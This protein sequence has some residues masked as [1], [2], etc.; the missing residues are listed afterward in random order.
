MKEQCLNCKHFDEKMSFMPLGKCAAFPDG[1][2]KDVLP[3]DFDHKKRHPEQIN[4]I[5]F[6]PDS[7]ISRLKPKMKKR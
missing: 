4:L 2:P 7:F 6:E 3:G 5:L 1:I